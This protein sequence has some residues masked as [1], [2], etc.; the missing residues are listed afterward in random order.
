MTLRRNRRDDHEGEQLGP[1]EEWPGAPSGYSDTERE[2]DFRVATLRTIEPGAPAPGADLASVG[3]H[4]VT[5]LAA[6][7]AA[8]EKVRREAEA[9]ARLERQRL[10]Q[11]AEELRARVI[12]DTEEQSSMM[13]RHASEA[14]E[15]AN[16]LRANAQA[17][18]ERSVHDAEEKAARI[19]HDAEE[20]ATK[21]ERVAEA[22]HGDL[23]GSIAS[24]EDRLNQL[25]ASLH[26]VASHLEE[27]AANR[28]PFDE[29]DADSPIGPQ[30]EA[31]ARAS[32]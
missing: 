4:V 7:E 1:G 15:R 32:M 13:L 17:L 27:L 20:R 5:V 23:L 3:E 24:T 10:Q 12:A 28:A 11:E 9:D 26:N 18:A 21:L 2:S 25:A 19:V 14:E 6:A 22:R 16:E 8:A 29:H 31:T 30:S